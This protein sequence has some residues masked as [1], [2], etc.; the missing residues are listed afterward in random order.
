VV[1][2]ARLPFAFS[3]RKSPI[4]GALPDVFLGALIAYDRWSTCKI[5][6][7]TL[8]SGIFLILVQQSRIPIGKTAGWH[9]FATWVQTPVC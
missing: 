9:T 7:A 3:Q 2:I 5:H 8:W 6:C 4:D 1:A